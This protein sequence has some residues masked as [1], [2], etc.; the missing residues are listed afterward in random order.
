M[1]NKFFYFIL[2]VTLLFVNAP[3]NAEMMFV[4]SLEQQSSLGMKLREL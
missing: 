2:T 4:N 3:S 1:N